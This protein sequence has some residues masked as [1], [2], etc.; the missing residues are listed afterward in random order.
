[1]TQNKELLCRYC[2]YPILKVKGA[3]GIPLDDLKTQSHKECR[4]FVSKTLVEQGATMS[5]FQE[6]LLIAL[7][8]EFPQLQESA[9][10]KDFEHRESLALGVIRSRFQTPMVAT[11]RTPWMMMKEELINRK[12]NIQ[13]GVEKH[14][15]P[16]EHIEQTTEKK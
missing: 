10:I 7:M 8:T 5:D 6:A 4:E 9:S 14:D 11:M 1:M 15:E 16:E 13:V 12:L 2:G 3:R